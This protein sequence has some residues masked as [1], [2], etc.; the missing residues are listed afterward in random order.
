MLLLIGVVEADERDMG[1]Q[2]D[3]LVFGHMRQIVFQPLQLPLADHPVI[4]GLGGKI[5]EGIRVD[6]VARVADIVQ[7]D[8]MHLPDIEGIVFRPPFAAERIK[9]IS[10]ARGIEV[11]VVI[12]RDKVLRHATHGDDLLEARVEREIIAHDIAFKD[13]AFRLGV[14]AAGQ[15]LACRV[16]DIADLPVRVGLRIAEHEA[17]EAVADGIV[18]QRKVDG[19]R[20]GA[21]GRDS[22]KP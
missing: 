10:V 18:D 2:H 4:G 8:E 22:A 11:E 13:Q 17:L 3:Q 12:A 15:H 1:V 20:Q 21:R 19:L 9:G 7:H 6:A 14:V 16:A 5:A